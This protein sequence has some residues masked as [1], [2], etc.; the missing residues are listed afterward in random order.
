MRPFAAAAKRWQE[1]QMTWRQPDGRPF[2]T[3]PSVPQLATFSMK[4]AAKLFAGAPT[5]L[6]QVYAAAAT[7]AGE[8]PRFALP[9]VLDIAIRTEMKDSESRNV[10]A[11]IPGSDPKLAAETVVLSA[12]LDH[13]G[14]DP[15]RE[16]DK[17][18]NGA[19][20]NASGVATTFEV[21]RA[22]VESGRRPKRSMLFLLVT[23]EEK[24]LIGAEYFARNP[25]VPADGLVA[26]V[27]LDMP[28]L[29]YDFTDVVAFGAERSG[30]GAVVERAAARIGVALSPDPM[31]EEGLFTRSDHYRFVE[32]GVPSV[33]LMTGFANGGEA[34]FREFLKVHYHR[35]SDQ[36]DLPIDYLAAAKFA[37]INYEIARELAEAAARPQWRAGDF[38]GSKFGGRRT[39]AD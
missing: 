7:D 35:P 21:A 6:E 18:Y 22:F 37:Q 13:E 19:L 39:Y 9:G 27:N 4:G 3:A 14:I 10:A 32:A 20:D 26:N 16:G 25:T 15:D 23:A 8:T 1:T 24:G 17:I 36:V 33:F 31:P 28:V 11:L 29:T 12:H 2:V 34:R 30:I 5:P 38:F